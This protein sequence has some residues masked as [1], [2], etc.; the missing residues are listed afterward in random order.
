LELKF[1]RNIFLKGVLLEFFSTRQGLNKQFQDF[2]IM[3]TEIVCFSLR[4]AVGRP[5]NRNN[6]NNNNNNNIKRRSKPAR[7][8][9]FSLLRKTC[10]AL[11]LTK[12]PS[13]LVP[14]FFLPE[15]PRLESDADLSSPSGTQIQHNWCQ[16]FTSPIF[17]IFI[18]YKLY[19]IYITCTSIT[20]IIIIV[21]RYEM[22]ATQLTTFVPLCSCNNITL[23]L[24]A[25]AAE[26]YW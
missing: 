25:I 5:P 17:S 22:T 10:T 12:T 3:E 16:T 18:L 6:N 9:G 24:A 1:L 21:N 23:N 8:K 13:H 26:T 11:R 15:V 20:E 2:K 14:G 7:A 4:Q 19:Y